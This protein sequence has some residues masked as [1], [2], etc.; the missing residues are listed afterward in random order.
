MKYSNS[1]RVKLTTLQTQ[2]TP[3]TNYSTMH[4]CRNK[5]VSNIST[6]VFK[7]F[8]P[9]LVFVVEWIFS[10]S[11]TK[12]IFH[13]VDL[14]YKY[15]LCTWYFRDLCNLSRWVLNSK[16]SVGTHKNFQKFLLCSL[17]YIATSIPDGICSSWQIQNTVYDKFKL[18]TCK[19]M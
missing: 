19:S 6:L 3:V 9:Y 13:R 15:L 14:W 10:E 1:R 18:I 2:V 11:R 8:I 5:E 7:C 12:L 4:L 17:N 16:F